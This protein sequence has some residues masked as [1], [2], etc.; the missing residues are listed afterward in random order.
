MGGWA[1]AGAGLQGPCCVEQKSEPLELDSRVF[2]EE[3][4]GKR[5]ERL[6]GI[7][8]KALSSTKANYHP[9]RPG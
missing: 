1:E 6:A 7:G 8:C 3:R 4:I 5:L 2:L 9:F